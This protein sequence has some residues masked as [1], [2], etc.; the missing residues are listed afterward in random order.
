L[1]LVV[2]CLLVGAVVVVLVFVGFFVGLLGFSFLVVVVLFVVVVSVVFVLVFVWWF[3]VGV[4]SDLVFFCRC[5][6]NAWGAFWFC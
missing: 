6:T 1:F 4:G 3:C 2:F 5:G